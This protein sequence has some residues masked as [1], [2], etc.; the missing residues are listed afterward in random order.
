MPILNSDNMYHIRTYSKDQDPSKELFT[1][2]PTFENY[3]AQ[4]RECWHLGIGSAQAIYHM[5]KFI[6][7]HIVKNIQTGSTFLMLCMEHESFID[8]VTVIYEELIIKLDKICDYNFA[9][10]KSKTSDEDYLTFHN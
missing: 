7:D 6:P 3:I 10:L 1:I 9:V 4:D 8:V 5:P 2:L